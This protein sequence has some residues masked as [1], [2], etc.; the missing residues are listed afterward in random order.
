MKNKAFPSFL[1]MA[2]LAPEDKHHA[3]RDAP[4]GQTVTQEGTPKTK[5][6]RHAIA[7][8]SAAVF[9]AAVACRPELKKFL[10]DGNY[11]VDCRRLGKGDEKLLQLDN[12]EIT[13]E[14]V[15]FGFSVPT[16]VAMRG[17]KAIEIP[18]ATSV[19]RVVVSNQ[20]PTPP[21]LEAAI[22]AMTERGQ[23][24]LRAIEARMVPFADP[25]EETEEV[26]KAKVESS[27][28]FAS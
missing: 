27:L 8:M 11:T 13:P 16:N 17:R 5:Q 4:K 18:I 22:K 24:T 3:N 15:I 12:A 10:T 20:I 1:R 7:L 9:S 21:Q 2:E 26:S 23:I 14:T 28:S 6:K 25:V 19:D